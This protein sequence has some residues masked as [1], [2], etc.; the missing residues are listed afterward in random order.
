MPSDLTTLDPDVLAQV[1]GALVV[2]TPEGQIVSWDRGAE[3][4]FGFSAEEALQRSI[5]ELVIPADRAAETREQM[6]KALAIGAAVYESERVRKDGSALPVG[7]SMR[8]VKDA[9]GRTLIAKNDRDITHFAYLRQSQRLDAKFRGLLEAAPDAMVIMNKE[10]RLVLVNT[11][12]EKLFGYTRE[13]LLGAAVEMLV[14]ERYRNGHPAHRR[15]YFHDPKPRPM[16]KGLDLAGRRKDGTEFPAEISLSPMETDEG[17]FATAAIRDVSARR[18]V[19]GKFRGLLESAPDAMVIVNGKGRIEL[20]NG[21]T[22]KLFGYGR[23]ELIGRE[24]EMLVPERFR[25]QHPGHRNRFFADPKVR[26]MGTGTELY[27]RRRDGTEFPV[28]ISLSPLETEEGVLVSSAI[29]DITERKR[30]EEQR[31]RALQ[32]ASRLKSEFL[33]N[34]SHELRTPLNAI[35]GFAEIVHDEKVGP[36]EPEQKEYLGDILTSS[37]HLLQLINDVLDLSKIEAGKMEFRP[38]RVDPA[39]VVVEIRDMLRSLAATKRVTVTVEA[40]GALDEVFIDP[41]KLK[42]VLYNYLSNALKFTPEG[43]RV[44][45]RVASEGADA[46]RLEV[47]DTGIGIRPEDIGRL[48]VEFQQLDATTAKKYPGTGLGLALTKRIVEA[49]GGQVGVRS[50]PGEGS[51]FFAVLPR[52]T[53]GRRD[54]EP[55]AD[56]R[57]AAVVGAPVIL[58]IEDEPRDQRWLVDTL[59][60]AGYEVES[61]G[62]GAAAIGRAQARLFDAIIVDLLLPDMSGEDVLRAIRAEGPNRGTPVIVATV[63]VDKGLSAGYQVVDV[64]TKP[65]VAA[66]LLGCLARIGVVADGSRTVLVVDDDPHALKLAESSLRDGGFRPICRSDGESGLEAVQKEAPT[67]IVLDLVMPE[68]SGFDFLGRLR[69]RPHGRNIPV[70]VWTQRD[71]TAEERE[72]LTTMAEAVVLKSAGTESLVEELRQCLRPAGPKPS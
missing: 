2:M 5:F 63:M 68:M 30:I 12:T 39:K 18:R 46:F 31:R 24:V 58:V 40:A 51:V 43:G 23:D 28:E 44:T 61:A 16:G 29:R 8:P 25:P 1:V 13:E 27:G 67:A 32:E 10:G 26:G 4:L 69:R 38:E 19:E 62:T 21:Q 72:R 52:T 54:A 6:K 47:E 66:D 17:T 15:G 48:F 36:L 14:P 65:L 42:Q 53:V 55:R 33:A 64:L 11:Q 60:R 56:A 34:M 37:R 3:I 7:V 57:A 41:A 9:E 22:E 35:I 49:Q 20:V 59:A 71:L 70:I 50:R 45:V